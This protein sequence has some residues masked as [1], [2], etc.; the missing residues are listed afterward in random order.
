MVCEIQIIVAEATG[1]VFSERVESVQPY[2]TMWELTA[3]APS[4]VPS[5]MEVVVGSCMHLS[6]LLVQAKVH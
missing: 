3:W 6:C 5:D 1:T 2:S 4:R